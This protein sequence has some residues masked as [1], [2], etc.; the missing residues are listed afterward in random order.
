[1]AF[2]KA[3]LL[4][5]LKKLRAHKVSC[6]ASEGHKVD[7]SDGTHQVQGKDIKVVILYHEFRL[8]DN[9]IDNITSGYLGKGD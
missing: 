2:S 8:L 6:L 3:N 5:D 1:M 7:L 4:S 9:L